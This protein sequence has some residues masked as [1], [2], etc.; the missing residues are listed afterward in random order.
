MLRSGILGSSK[1]T[2]TNEVNMHGFCT[3][4]FLRWLKVVLRI[5]INAKNGRYSIGRIMVGNFFLP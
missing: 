2:K 5:Y 1:N 3:Y 4:T